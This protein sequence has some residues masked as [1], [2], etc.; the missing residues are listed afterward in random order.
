LGTATV[1]PA[2][3]FGLSSTQ[4]TSK[5][6]SP[7]RVAKVVLSCVAGLF[8][9]VVI[10]ALS[11]KSTSGNNVEKQLDQAITKGNLFPPSVEN[12]HNLYYQLKASNA[13][14][15]TLR[16]YRERIIT[17]LT[18]T[19]NQLL[20]SRPASAARNQRLISGATPPKI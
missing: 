11:T 8:L 14:E 10:I 9:L 7:S 15:D 5:G 2:Y 6:A 16:R 18:S 1:A 19:P 12:A 13:S 3:D 20:A 17:L 4:A